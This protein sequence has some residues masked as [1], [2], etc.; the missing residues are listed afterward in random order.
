MSMITKGIIEEVCSPHEVRVR[1][2]RLDGVTSAPNF[3]SSEELPVATICT[4]P[5]CYMNL[6][7]GDVVFVGYEDNTERKLIV[8]G[9][10]SREAAS[11]SMVDITIR[12]LTVAEGFQVDQITNTELACLNNCTVNIQRE[13]ELLAQRV[14]NL[15][16]QLK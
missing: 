15:E 6:Q 1:I 10:L 5:S 11:S 13:F 7:I 4:L 14:S 12:N 16:E 3:V 2:P 8:L 9:H